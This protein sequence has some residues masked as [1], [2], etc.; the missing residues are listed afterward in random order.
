MLLS[1]CASTNSICGGFSDWVEPARKEYFANDR[2]YDIPRSTQALLRKFMPELVVHPDGKPPIDFA[3][4]LADVDLV[5][6][7][8]ERKGEVVEDISEDTVASM[9]YA[10]MCQTYLRPGHE[11]IQSDPPYPWYA[12]VYRSPAPHDPDEQWLYLKYN[13]VFDWSG[14]A[15]KLS[16]GSRLSTGFIGADLSKWHRLDVHTSV[17]VAL[18]P[19]G[20]Q[21]LIII[22]QHNYSKTY[23]AGRDFDPSK[24]VTLAAALRSNELYVDDGSAEPR[25]YRV[26]TFSDDTPYLIAGIN[27][28]YYRGMDLVAGKNAGGVPVPMRL[29]F[30]DPK[31]P[32]AAYPGKL[33]PPRPLFGAIYIGRDGPE[34]YDYHTP[35]SVYA[36]N[37][38]ASFGYWQDGDEQL[39]KDLAKILAES[40]SDW[41]DDSKY[42]KMM[43]RMQQD[44][45]RDL[46]NDY[47]TK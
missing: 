41:R 3:D 14:L 27:R 36:L 21:R 42:N 30:I 11:N 38:L 19:Q 46:R 45:A 13:V 29:E 7:Y 10:E 6:A 47:T 5:F 28:P 39:A 12:Q 32:L 20:R 35:P 1:S 15:N 26:V 24:R 2:I 31:A 18:D 34:G 22:M 25:E 44:L 37:R 17:V 23:L 33:A 8:G 9:S 4:Y 43:E 16:I 40:E